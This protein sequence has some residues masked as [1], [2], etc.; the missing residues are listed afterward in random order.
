[1]LPATDLPQVHVA[2]PTPAPVAVQLPEPEISSIQSNDFFSAFKQGTGSFQ[3]SNSSGASQMQGAPSTSAILASS[4]VLLQRTVRTSSQ[5]S[6]SGSMLPNPPSLSPPAHASTNQPDTA[7][8][9]TIWGTT[10]NATP[11]SNSVQR[12][13]AA[14][15]SSSTM[16]L[17]TAS[18][19]QMWMYTVA[20][21]LALCMALFIGRSVLSWSQHRASDVAE[22]PK[23]DTGGLQAEYTG[24]STPC[25]TPYL[26]G[27]PQRSPAQDVRISVLSKVTC[28]VSMLRCI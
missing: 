9:T 3:V 2:V 22:L 17:D 12:L 7:T 21:S 15:A 4:N 20:G 8:Q 18:F 11:A 5:D 1:M 13:A 25:H 24:V 14:L 28:T 10:L 16:V 6:R 27:S 19:S 26:M 23:S